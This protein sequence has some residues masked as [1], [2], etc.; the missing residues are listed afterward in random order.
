MHRYHYRIVLHHEIYLVKFRVMRV[1][2][3]AV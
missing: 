3:L 1:E 2:Q